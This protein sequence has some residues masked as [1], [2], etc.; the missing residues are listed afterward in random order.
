MNRY[1][2][3]VAYFDRRRF[4]ALRALTFLGVAAL[5]AAALWAAGPPVQQWW[6]TLFGRM[7]AD[8]GPA[9]KEP[10]HVATPNPKPAASATAA[11]AQMDAVAGTES[12]IASAPQRLHLISASPGRSAREGV[13][14]IG[15][16][17]ENP[18]TYVAGAILV[19]G[20]RLAEIHTDRVVLER[21][22]EKVALFLASAQ[23][24]AQGSV[25]VA[26]VPAMPSSPPPVELLGVDRLGEVIRAMS[27][28]EDDLL[29][30]LQVFP[31]R[32]AGTFARLGLKPADV[33]VSIDSVAVTDAKDALEYLQSLTQGAAVSVRVRR[34][35]AFHVL[36]LDGT[37]VEA[38]NSR[39]NTPAQPAPQDLARTFQ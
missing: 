25:D 1:Q 30:G 18:Q 29:Q 15:T 24:Q 31:G 16:D 27:Y 19:N 2:Q 36:S 3:E 35:S 9:R 17:P 33:I 4:L 8:A 26:T 32:E 28:Y 38:A 11:V 23:V 34:D 20:A 12:S 37:L 6:D 22:K 5:V 14:R 7:H 10:A 39:S 21:G 13:A